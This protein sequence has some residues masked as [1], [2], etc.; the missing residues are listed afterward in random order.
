MVFLIIQIIFYSILLQ[1]SNPK[2]IQESSNKTK[3][4]KKSIF[5]AKILQFVKQ[6]CIFA[7]K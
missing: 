6:I 7:D 2:N 1:V 3:Y 5:I 4:Y